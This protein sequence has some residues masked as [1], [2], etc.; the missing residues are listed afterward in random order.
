LYITFFF[1]CFAVVLEALSLMDPRAEEEQHPIVKL[2]YN[3]LL[4][5][6]NYTI[7]KLFACKQ[8]FWQQA[9]LEWVSVVPE[10]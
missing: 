3:L 4:K 1:S 5:P 10:V 6:S 8:A 7:P 9:M 2:M